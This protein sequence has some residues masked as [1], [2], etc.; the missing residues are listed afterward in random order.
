MF[1]SECVRSYKNCNNTTTM[2]IVV[3]KVCNKKIQREYQ[4][5]YITKRNSE[6][7]FCLQT[8]IILYKLYIK[9]KQRNWKISNC[10]NGLIIKINIYIHLNVS[11]FMYI[12]QYFLNWTLSML[13]LVYQTKNFFPKMF[14]CFMLSLISTPALR[15]HLIAGLVWVIDRQLPQNTLKLRYWNFGQTATIVNMKQSCCACC[16]TDPS[17]CNSTSRQNPPFSTIAVTFEPTQRFRC[18]SRFRISDQISI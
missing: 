3:K 7:T 6:E 14:S 15:P 2:C 16:R 9:E 10:H 13:C 8:N 12:I 1:C 11:H 17:R 5:L 18:P 4:S